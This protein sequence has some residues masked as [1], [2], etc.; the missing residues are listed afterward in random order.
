MSKIIKRSPMGDSAD[1]NIDND[2]G[3]NGITWPVFKTEMNA[4]SDVDTLN[5][6]I[7]CPGGSVY[8]GR[9]IHAAIRLHKARNKVAHI[10]GLAGSTASIIALAADEVHIAEDGLIMIHEPTGDTGKFLDEARDYILNVYT[11]RSGAKRA[12]LREMMRA[13]TWFNSGDAVQFGF[14]DFITPPTGLAQEQDYSQFNNTMNY[15]N[16]ETTARARRLKKVNEARAKHCR[17]A[18]L[19]IQ[20]QRRE[21]AK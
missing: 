6:H 16:S 4:V 21:A 18:A 9:H 11:S 12:D 1:V 5:I 14:A 7:N 8:H 3:P 10:H 17:Q 19:R 15:F 13:E 2:I 20:K